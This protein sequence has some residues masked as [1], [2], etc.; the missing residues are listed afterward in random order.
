MAIMASVCSMFPG[1]FPPA[2]QIERRKLLESIDPE[3]ELF[4]A[5]DAKFQE[6][7]DD[8]AALAKAYRRR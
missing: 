1:G 6:C 7:G 8:L 5:E 2:D 3:R 4:A